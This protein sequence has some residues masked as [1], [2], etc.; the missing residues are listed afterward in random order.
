LLTEPEALWLLADWAG[1]AVVDLP[2][3][4]R[5][6]M[7]ECGRLPLALAICG[8]MVRDGTAW[9]D[10][11]EALRE[12][13]LEF[14]DHPHGNVL[15]SIKVGVDALPPDQ[16][17]RFVELSV[18][19]PDE[20]VPEA[21]VTTLWAHTVGLQDRHARQLVTVLK[22][23]ALI[24]VDT[25]PVRPGEVPR[26]RLSLH[27]LL[28][29]YATHLSADARGLHG[30]VVAAY[31]QRR[32]D[33]GL[34]HTLPDDGY[35]HRRLAWHLEESGDAAGL[36]ALLR[37]ETA[38]G[39]N[40]WFVASERLG[41]LAGFAADLAR[42]AR[43]AEDAFRAGQGAPVLGLQ[44]RYCLMAS[45]LASLAD[46]LEPPLLSA[47]VGEG[48]W[49]LELALGYARRIPHRERRVYGLLALVPFL[50][51]AQRDVVTTEGFESVL[52]IEDVF[53]RGTALAALVPHLPEERLHDALEAAL[54]TGA[55]PWARSEALVALLPRLPAGRQEEVIAVALEDAFAFQGEIN[56]AAVLAPL[57]PYLPPE[58][59]GILLDEALEIALSIKN[60]PPEE[61]AAVPP[62]VRLELRRRDPSEGPQPGELAEIQCS[63]L[64]ALAPHLPDE[65]RE[66]V[67]TEALKAC[68]YIWISGDRAKTLAEIVPQLSGELLT[69]ALGIVRE[70]EDL[71]T[72]ADALAV[73][74]G[75][76][77]PADRQAMLPEAFEGVC[78]HGSALRGLCL[79]PHLQVAQRERILFRALRAAR[80][81]GGDGDISTILSALAPDLEARALRDVFP[82]ALSSL[83]LEGLAALA[84]HV[85][86]DLMGDMLEAA[87]GF[88]PWLR[89]RALAVL[90]P[91]LPSV[92][93][94]ALEGNLAP[95]RAN[96]QES[97]GGSPS[98]RN[99]DRDSVV[100]EAIQAFRSRPDQEKTL[101]A[102]A[103][104]LPEEECAALFRAAL[105]ASRHSYQGGSIL[106][107][108][109]PHLPAE[110]LPEALEQAR[111]WERGDR[112][113]TLAALARRLPS[114]D[115]EPVLA[116]A[117]EDAL[118]NEYESDRARALGALA[119]Y[120][121][122]GLQR[123]AYE[124]IKDFSDD[125]CR[126]QALVA[127]A[128]HLP[129]TSRL[130]ALQ[131]ARQMDSPADRAR[132]LAA[133][134]PHVPVTVQEAILSD[135]LLAAH[136]SGDQK[137][138]CLI[139]LTVAAQLARLP[140]TRL[141]SLWLDTIPVLMTMERRWCLLGLTKL[142][143]VLRWCNLVS[144]NSRAE[145]RQV[146]PGPS[147][148]TSGSSPN[149]H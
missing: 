37:E 8:A 3:T 96:G 65:Q 89:A 85:P 44:V 126:S 138:E 97:P 6:V 137:P 94:A 99:N 52:A 118:A 103:P 29:D 28:Y 146:R 61:K 50:D 131:E 15:R 90:V 62:G 95:A 54:A 40:G 128:P 14:L 10:L 133:L 145:V 81:I 98:T 80:T 115:F 140:R 48:I 82:V 117:L 101:A 1:C 60:E 43:L 124:V 102:L 9:A 143:P 64:V 45:S 12:A 26:R 135:S 49:P 88:L 72:R 67:L 139:S 109:A 69:A 147:S 122:A 112:S 107:K 86:A 70:M 75:H 100:T 39:F 136:A 130:D 123:R 121:T 76:L 129:A 30:Q 148:G 144:V 5:R 149:P 47:L 57:L 110:L 32:P 119:P 42:A 2:R 120:L 141:G 92:P 106:I 111:R 4:A 73:V 38:E 23:R 91:Y 105:Q 18:F 116:E 79:L 36:H 87:R 125:W 46:A 93:H 21:A 19:P 24:Q 71:G 55:E 34:W 114:Q 22:Q 41:H 27:D 17:R 13:D 127:F 31:R 20:S 74:V 113:G 108:L 66:E 104:Y 132:T 142:I 56:F 7:T 63:A 83:S 25:E 11:L 77:P 68:R 58:E 84:P 59:R 78:A 53:A 134:L 16:R 35:V 51:A 33:E